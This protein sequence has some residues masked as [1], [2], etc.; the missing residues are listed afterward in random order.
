MLFRPARLAGLAD[1]S[2]TL[3][4]RRW[5]R[6]T[7]RAGGTLTTPVGVLAIDDVRSIDEDDITDDDARRAGYAGRAAVL[8]E[9]GP[10][11]RTASCTGS[12]STSPAPIPGSP[13]ASSGD[14]TDDDVAELARRLARLDAASTHGPWTAAVLR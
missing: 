12:S 5:K 13:C 2:V 11:T 3:A 7:V 8:A 1:G 4:F 14:L 9:L 6:P 10:A